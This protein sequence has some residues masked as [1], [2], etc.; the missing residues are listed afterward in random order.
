MLPFLFEIRI[1]IRGVVRLVSTMW[2][3]R[4][5]SL[6][7]SSSLLEA[8]PWLRSLGSTM[9]TTVEF[10]GLHLITSVLNEDSG[11]EGPQHRERQH[12]CQACNAYARVDMTLSVKLLFLAVGYFVLKLLFAEQPHVRHRKSRCSWP[13]VYCIQAPVG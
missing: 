10:A 11:G 1:G 8:C 7:I 3:L 5:I 9:G 4:S 12:D 13:F 6:S 2:T